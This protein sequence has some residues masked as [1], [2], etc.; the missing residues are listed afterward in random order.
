[1]ARVALVTGEIDGTID[2]DRQARVDLDDAVVFALVPVVTAPR[3]VGDVLDDELLVR[4]QRDALASASLSLGD[5]SLEYGIEPFGWYDELI[6]VAHVA[7][8]HGSAARQDVV[9]SGD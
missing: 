6:S 3:L 9:E 8:G 7:L 4:W 2:V 5:R 1:M